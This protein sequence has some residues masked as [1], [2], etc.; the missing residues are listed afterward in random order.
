MGGAPGRR[1]VHERGVCTMTTRTVIGLDLSL[2]RTGVAVWRNGLVV[3]RSF[4]TSPDTMDTVRWHQIAVRIWP[5]ITAKDT[6][7]VIEGPV[8][9]KGRGNTTQT[10]AE[11]RGVIKY[12]LMLR[13]VP[14]VEPRPTTVK[15]YA[16]NGSWGKETMLEQARA[17]MA[18]ECSV[19]P[20]NYDEADALW[21]M[22]MGCH[23]DGHPLVKA[24]MR[25]NEAVAATWPHVLAEKVRAA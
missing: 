18:T 21:C 25:R 19:W 8:D 7:A 10:L 6:H 16:G 20:A 9:I 2:S 13:G 4:E 11:L 1:V 15:K 14:Y 22:A 5:F 12:G 23:R 24:T 17:Q 3:L